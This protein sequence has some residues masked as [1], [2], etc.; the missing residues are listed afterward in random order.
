MNIN[1]VVINLMSFSLILYMLIMYFQRDDEII[2]VKK[3]IS[4]NISIELTHIT[5]EKKRIEKKPIEEKKT[6]T[7]K[8][9]VKKN[10]I[11]DKFVKLELRKK[12]I[13]RFRDQVLVKNH[14]QNSLKETYMYFNKMRTDS[15]MIPLKKNHI[16]E[17]TA[18]NHAEYIFENFDYIPSEQSKHYQN[19]SFIFFTG[20]NPYQRAQY[21]EHFTNYVSE[22]IAF[23]DTA[24]KTID[25]LM[26]AIYH[27]FTILNFTFDEVGLSNYKL[28]NNCTFSF[29][30]N[31]SNSLLNDLCQKDVNATS[32]DFILCKD[33]KKI[34]RSSYWNFINTISKQN[35]DYVLYPPNRG[36]NIIRRFD[37]ERP[38][39]TPD[40]EFTGNPI[41]IQF[42]KYFYKR[43]S[44]DMISFRVQEYLG[45]FLE[46]R[47]LKKDTDPNK[48][49]SMYE[50]AFFPL[51]I[52]KAN[53]RY[54]AEFK[55]TV[56]GVVQEPII[57]SFTTGYKKSYM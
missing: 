5:F 21:E 35:P 31:P 52:L 47:I 36:K 39:P 2:V 13:Q 48:I 56:D 33:D 19:E 6:V 50:Y 41:S 45:D 32:R 43:K 4:E 17:K 16:L 44:V 26:T 54:V 1:N 46:G 57:W 51:N 38:D 8:K 22:G 10:K 34:S 9:K 24:K 23:A 55:Y 3:P 42:N 25:C 15:G 28:A 14:C 29:V 20:V 53:R 12:E 37:G 30:H 7:L 27:R 40:L 18:T 11:I 49:F